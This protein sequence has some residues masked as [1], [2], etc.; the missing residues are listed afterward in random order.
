[1]MINYTVLHI[2]YVDGQPTS[3]ANKK[4]M[5]KPRRYAQILQTD[6]GRV[7]EVIRRSCEEEEKNV[8]Y[9]RT[10]FYLGNPE[11]S[12]FYLASYFLGEPNDDLLQLNL[13]PT[14]HNMIE[15]SHGSFGVKDP[16][17]IV[18]IYYVTN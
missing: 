1:M 12:D 14:T 7:D 8:K 4:S 17:V 18:K 9:E 6:G 10:D 16:L 3:M 11:L 13:N 15:R 5:C 2:V